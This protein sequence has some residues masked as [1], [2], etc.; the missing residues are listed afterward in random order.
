LF[1]VFKVG[2][3]ILLF[4]PG[5][6]FVQT[7]D[8]H[9][10][11]EKKP[12]FE[13]GLE[14]ILWSAIVWVAAFS[15]PSCGWF[16]GARDNLCSAISRSISSE[17]SMDELPVEIIKNGAS[18]AYLFLWVCFWSFAIS[19]SWG[20]AR[21]TKWVDSYIKYVTGRD[22]YPSVAFKFFR[23][24]IDKA[25]EVSV[26]GTKYIGV[27]ISAPDTKEDKYI[28]ITDPYVMV[29]DKDGAYSLEHLKSSNSRRR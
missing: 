16:T 21:K 1:D 23:E 26:Q 17:S 29:Q 13:K 11:R 18:S 19:T 12:Q 28:I 10:L 2:I 7:K 9:L 5:F 4:I 25:V 24:N 22:W 3:Y 8:H 20:Y 6:I 27:L 15:L 14:I